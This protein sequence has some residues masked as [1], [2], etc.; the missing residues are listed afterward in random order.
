MTRKEY[1][2]GEVAKQARYPRT[3]EQIEE[4]EDFDEAFRELM[5][6]SITTIQGSK[7]LIPCG[8]MNRMATPAM[9]LRPKNLSPRPGSRPVPGNERLHVISKYI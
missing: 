6:E 5:A 2:E 3:K 8:P 1:L 7:E 4:D 9:C